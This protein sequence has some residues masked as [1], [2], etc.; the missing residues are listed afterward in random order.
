MASLS[1]QPDTGGE[2]H[3]SVV[4]NVLSSGHTILGAA[5]GIRKTLKQLIRQ[6][7]LTVPQNAPLTEREGIMLHLWFLRI[8]S[9]P[10]GI[11]P[12]HMVRVCWY[13]FL[14]FISPDHS[15]A[16]SS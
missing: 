16:L 14:E 5:M 10:Q 9:L 4:F 8:D 6:L 13:M 12:C 7:L 1:H 11:L 15:Y 2:L 3:S